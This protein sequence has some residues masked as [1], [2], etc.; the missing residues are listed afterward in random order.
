MFLYLLNILGFTLD[1]V[2][3]LLLCFL[4]QDQL[5]N[6][7]EMLKDLGVTQAMSVQDN[8]DPVLRGGPGFYKVV[9]TGPSGH[10]IRSCPNLRGIPIGMLV[11]GNKV[12]AVGEVVSSEGTWVQLD[13][14]SMVEFCENDEGEAWS[15]A[16][17]AGGNQYLR[18]EDE[19]VLE[20]GS[21]TPPPSPFSLQ[22]FRRTPGG[23]IVPGFDYSL[24]NN[25]GM[26]C[27]CTNP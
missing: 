7:E 6:A 19:Q 12:K 25:R 5:E 21:Q 2:M 16:R 17:D 27:P 23:T 26:T 20:Q 4:F 14:N 24:L 3:D 13:K 22:I 10:N 18:H 15:L 11:L 8:D 1:S 9:K